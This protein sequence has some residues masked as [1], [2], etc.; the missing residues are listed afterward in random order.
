VLLLSAESRFAVFTHLDAALFADVGNVARHFSDLNVDKTSYGAGV[1]LHNE[2]TTLGRLD[3]AHG[4]QGWHL[5]VSTNEP[6]RLPRVRQT[7][8][9]IPFTP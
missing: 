6:M 8:A 2:T 7:T 1:R 9:I 3:V 5:V 4:P